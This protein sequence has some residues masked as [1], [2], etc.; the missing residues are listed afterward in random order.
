MESLVKRLKSTQLLQ[1]ALYLSF[2]SAL[3]ACGQPYAVTV[4]PPVEDPAVLA[5]SITVNEGATLTNSST[6]TLKLKKQYADKMYV[7]MTD[8]CTAGSDWEPYAETK[9]VSLSG[10]DSMKLIYV[11]FRN[12][13]GTES[14][15]FSTSIT[16]DTQAPVIQIP[17]KPASLT[18]AQDVEFVLQATDN[19]TGVDRL[20]CRFNSEA[21][22]ACS[23][24]TIKR[25]N[26][27]DGSYVFQVRAFD[28][29]GNA[30][31]VVEYGWKVDSR[32]PTVAISTHPDSLAKQ[33][34]ASFGF[35]ASDSTGNI[36]S[37]KCQMDSGTLQTCSS[38]MN[39]NSLTQA[40]HTF[41]LY[42]TDHFGNDV[43]KTYSWQ[44]DSI[45]PVLT[46][47]TVPAAIM[48]EADAHFTFAATDTN[49][50]TG[51]GSGVDKYFCKID[52]DQNREC[53]SPESENG[54]GEGRHDYTVTAVDRAGNSA[55][56]VYSF[57]IDH[58]PP[59][60]NIATGP[61]PITTQTSV[62]FGLQ[63]VDPGASKSSGV[64][65]IVCKLDN[66]AESVCTMSPAFSGLSDGAHVVQFAVFDK[67][68]NT[69]SR[70]S[71]FTVDSTPPAIPDI[72]TAPAP[73]TTSRDAFFRFASS[74]GSGSGI[75]TYECQIDT[76][77]ISKCSETRTYLNLLVGNHSFKVTAI[78]MAGNR[79]AVAQADWVIQ[80]PPRPTP[81]PTPVPTPV[82]TPAPTPVPTP[83]PTPVPTPAPTPVPTPAPT[84]VPTPAPTPAPTPVPTPM[85]T[86]VATPEPTPAPTPEPTPE[87]TP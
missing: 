69:T 48:S 53:T 24:G 46:F 77:V 78:D 28:K 55:N 40:S 23:A 8:G 73:T 50:S 26:F 37:F 34:M 21:F 42:L 29:A 39:Y 84:P 47:G 20:E 14:A 82:P 17:V 83:A 1:Q 87:P 68:G 10:P 76:Q 85:P 70:S 41:T 67:A 65:R 30:S 54:L 59:T 62:S 58:T 25:S 75:A 81:T 3:F 49:G 56:K 72:S 7:T 35:S 19:L 79:S 12:K 33:N 22:T 60:L 18:K 80:D 2:I 5:D 64:D 16:L 31:A 4:K 74:D 9:T 71:I 38:P 44:I 13:G 43:S 57:F 61:S 66:G 52:S 15:C 6:V 63:V 45:A 27:A 11:K 86:P 32:A 36:S 51:D